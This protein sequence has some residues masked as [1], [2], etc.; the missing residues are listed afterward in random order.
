MACRNAISRVPHRSVHQLQIDE[1]LAAGVPLPLVPAAPVHGIQCMGS[2]IPAAPVH[3]IQCMGSIVPAAPVHGIHASAS[4]G[5]Y[6]G[7]TPGI[8]LTITG[9]RPPE[10]ASAPIVPHRGPCYAG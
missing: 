2:I 1:L 7:W 3:G 10:F 9:P 5:L 4:H 8:T 6:T